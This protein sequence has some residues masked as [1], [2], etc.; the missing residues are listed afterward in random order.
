MADR[1]DGVCG[2][3]REGAGSGQQDRLGGTPTP[4]GPQSIPG[5]PLSVPQ[6]LEGLRNHCSSPTLDDYTPKH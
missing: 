4:A 2:M 1:E 3:W 6:S 5:G